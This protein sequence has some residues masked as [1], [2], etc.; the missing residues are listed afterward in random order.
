VNGDLYGYEP[1]KRAD[2]RYEHCYCQTAA[3]G[4]TR[5]WVGHLS[6]YVWHCADHLPKSA[7][8]LQAVS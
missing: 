1:E 5:F 6:R 8:T 7:R 4:A 2:A 3:V